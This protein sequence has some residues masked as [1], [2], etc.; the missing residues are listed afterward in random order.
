M[1]LAGPGSRRR[2]ECHASDQKSIHETFDYYAYPPQHWLE[3]KTN[4][5]MERLLNEAWR[6]TKVVG[7]FPNENATLILVAARLYH[8]STTTWS[9]CK[10]MNMKLPNEMDQEAIYSL[11]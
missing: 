3:I 4:N 9:T 2:G 5:P 11:A 8:V 7:A 1:R 6:I 10:Y